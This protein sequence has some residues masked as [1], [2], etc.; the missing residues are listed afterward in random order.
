MRTMADSVFKYNEI[1]PS[2]ILEVPNLN[3]AVDL[4]SANIG[5]SFVCK[6]TM[7]HKKMDNPLT[8]FSVGDLEDI[9]SIILAYTKKDSDLITA[10]LD[11]SK[12][13]FKNYSV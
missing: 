8:Y 4:V 11:I 7:L 1:A 10:F 13:V 12:E 5:L 3:M 6:T 9:P 2:N